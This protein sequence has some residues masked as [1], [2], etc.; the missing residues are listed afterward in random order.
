MNPTKV[1]VCEK[2]L[3]WTESI[4]KSVKFQVQ[5]RSKINNSYVFDIFVKLVPLKWRPLYRK[6]LDTEVPISHPTSLSLFGF[7]IHSMY[8]IH[9]IK[10]VHSHS[11]II[12]K[13]PP[14]LTSVWNC[15]KFKQLSVNPIS[16]KVLFYFFS[17]IFSHISQFKS[18]DKFVVTFPLD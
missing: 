7:D 2:H 16:N 13:T 6:L 3:Y 9:S 10:H 12:S 17:I 5:A 4:W 8:N 1:I 11:P 14:S 15:V 18:I